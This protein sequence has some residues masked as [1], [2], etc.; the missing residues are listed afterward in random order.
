MGTRVKIAL[1]E[2]GT[3]M[4]GNYFSA[5]L[6]P[7]LS[8][9]PSIY[10]KP[11]RILAIS[12]I[13]GNFPALRKLLIKAGIIDKN[14]QWI[15]GDGHLVIVGDCLHKEEQM[16]ECLWLIYSLEYKALS[17][18]GYV[19][20]ILGNHEIMNLNGN[21]RYAH[22]KYADTAASGNDYVILYDGNRELWRWLQT[23]NM[24]ERIGDVLFVHG[25][26][27]D[28]INQ[29]NLPITEINGLARPHYVNARGT[30]TDDRLK[31]I[32]NSRK[33]PF[34]F[35]GYYKE[36]VNETQIDTTL[37]LFGVSTIVTGHTPVRHVA[38]FYNNK[39]ININTRH[40]IGRSEALLIEG[41]QFFRMNR[42]GEK[43]RIK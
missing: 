30:L 5:R 9:E 42:R 6:K 22:P 31:M 34:W 2:P 36:P 32:L 26:I 13:E 23:K 19:H 18:G 14:Y 20:F 29:L 21:W 25:G 10:N 15:F 41:D 4:T 12:D 17:D 28:E 1:L 43:E 16:A 38:S 40:S 3:E 35:R 37:D 39:V 8:N 33:S 24:M 27:S 7:D 11:S